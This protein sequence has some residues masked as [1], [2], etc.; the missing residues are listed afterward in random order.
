MTNISIRR[1][2]EKDQFAVFKTFR[3]SLSGL[4]RDLG[5]VEDLPTLKDIEKLYPY[6]QSYLKHIFDTCD[7]FWV[8]EANGEV[9]GYARSILRDGIRQLTEFFILPDYQSQKAGKRLLELCF[10]RAGAQNRVI[11][12]SPDPRAL[13]RYLKTG[14]RSQFTIYEWSRKPEII[15]FETDLVIETMSDTPRTISALYNIDRTIIGYTREIDH[16][17]L[18]EHRHG[19]LYSRNEKVVGYSYFEHRAGPIAM[20]HNSDFSTALAHIETEMT[21]TVDEVFDEIIL[22]VP[23]NNPTALEYVLKRGYQISF[24]FE[25]FLTEQSFGQYENYI[26]IDPILTT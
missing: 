12:A 14:L 7:Q 9:V 19:H 6:Y 22:C 15:P 26:F 18:M 11:C 3:I 21:K 13:S 10:P 24:F 2:E 16:H 8:A 5:L 4:L 1:G 20:L 17:W 23:M 25:H